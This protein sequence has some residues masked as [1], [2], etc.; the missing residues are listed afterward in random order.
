MS[1]A[2]PSFPTR[3][4]Y[5]S[6]SKLPDRP[7]PK[8]GAALP[9][10]PYAQSTFGRRPEQP[11]QFGQSTATQQQHGALGGR[12][13]MEKESNAL[14]E[15]SEEQKDEIN[16]A[17][18]LFDLDRDRHLD[19]HELRVAMRSLG[20]SVP[21]PEVAQIMQSH[22]VPKPQFKRGPPGRGQQ[23]YHS[24]Q[25]LLPQNAFQRIAA[26]KVFERDPTD[27]VERALLLFD[28]DQR[29]YIEVEDIRRVSRE[30]G[31]TGLEDE[32]IQAMVEEFDYDGTGSV[33]KE[34]FYAICLQ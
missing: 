22:G 5:A 25:L 9:P 19:Y 3:N 28:P 26:Q 14:S 12:Q 20:F 21:K 23:S 29:G 11:Y 27:E 24:S 34:A 6:S 15:L 10:Q 13:S 4:V 31:E 1:Q 33:A 30:L 2:N 32:E 17:F 8:S 18:S 16:E 7:A